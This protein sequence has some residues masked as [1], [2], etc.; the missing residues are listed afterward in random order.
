MTNDDPLMEVVRNMG[1]D[2]HRSAQ[3]LSR[4]FT[5]MTDAL[6]PGQTVGE[7]ITEQQARKLLGDACLEIIDDLSGE[8]FEKL[9]GF[10]DALAVR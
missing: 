2:E 10:E 7:A 6:G 3:I 5:K 8:E 1:F 4:F 9:A